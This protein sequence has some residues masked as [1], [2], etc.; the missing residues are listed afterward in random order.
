MT[1]T[2]CARNTMATEVLKMA[3][4]SYYS[5]VSLYV[6]FSLL[7]SLMHSLYNS[8]DSLHTCNVNVYNYKTHRKHTITM[9][10][11]AMC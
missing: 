4:N 8:V 1:L 6:A 11:I 9:Q 7:E 5:V 10:R 2:S 3:S